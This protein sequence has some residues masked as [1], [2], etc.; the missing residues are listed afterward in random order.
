[1]AKHSTHKPKKPRGPKGQFSRRA[2]YGLNVTV[3]IVAALLVVILLNVVVD[4]GYRRIQPTVKQWLRYDL[5][6]TRRYSLSEQT[7]QVLADLDGR[8]RI[9]TLFRGTNV[10]RQRIKDLTNEYNLYGQEKVSVTHLPFDVD[11]AGRQEFYGAL[12]DHFASDLQPLQQAIEEGRSSL[13][14]VGQQMVQAVEPLQQAEE[15]QGLQDAQLV[16]FVQSVRSALT[17]QQSNIE[18]IDNQ[19]DRMLGQEL[20]NYGEVRSTLESQFQNLDEG[21]FQ[22]AIQR[23]ERAADDSQLPG[24]VQNELLKAIDVF[25]GARSATEE[26]LK[27]LRSVSVPERY[28]EVRSTVSSQESVVILGPQRVQVLAVQDL[29]RQPSEQIRQREETPEMVFLGE[30]KLTGAL[31][32]LS[33]DR[34]PL[35]V[36][37]NLG[38][39]PALGR[40]GNYTQVAERLRSA[41]FQVEQWSPGGGQSQRG[42]MGRQRQQNTEPPQPDEGQ[43]AVWIVLPAG[44]SQN[45]M[46]QMGGNS[47]KEQ[48]ADHLESRLEA[49]DSV[50]MLLAMS[51][52]SRFGQADPLVSLLEPWGITPQLDRALM[53]MEQQPNRQDRAVAQHEVRHW[54]TGQDAL[55]VT[56]ALGG[57]GGVFLRASPLKLGE[58][59]GVEHYPLVRLSGDRL[60]A[61][62]DMETLSNPQS[63]SFKESTASSS[64]LIGA[65]AKRD[66]QRL[67][68]VAD[69]V[70]ATDTITTA[71]RLGGQIVPQMA[72]FAGAAFPANSELFVNSVFWLAGLDHLIAASPRTQDIRRID[73]EMS[74]TALF[75]YRWVTI[76][77]LPL[78]ALTL[79]L[80]VWFVRR[81]D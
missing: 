16:Q 68:T 72:E 41:N 53:R 49:G 37:V 21:L 1:M 3:A 17:R 44:Q 9:Y 2:V 39:Q 25:N 71:G 36:F 26:A 5:T 13:E 66:G 50:M 58:T 45:P 60:W 35:A 78:A 61:E 40:Q 14:A 6:A 57:M 28:N 7:Q 67:V 23:F 80:G 24:Q 31:L 55:P 76:G 52:A 10:H 65:A 19:L 4:R 63:A 77:G 34:S 18:E 48:A 59:A 32:S 29:Y 81:R 27:A 38:Q 73:E 33:M 54:P 51:P 47:A 43:R 46:T 8:Y 22:V 79:G 11:V 69:Q 12:K 74:Q 20:P 56:Q 62:S 15:H 70:W 75:T 42:M 64:F 30:E